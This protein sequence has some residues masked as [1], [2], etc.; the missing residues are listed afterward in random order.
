MT[1]KEIIKAFEQADKDWSKKKRWWNNYETFRNFT[2]MG[3]CGYFFHQQNV[4][5][6]D[7]DEFLC[8]LWEKHKTKFESVYDF[9]NRKERLKAIRKVLNVLKQQI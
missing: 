7:I 4:S 9:N 3:L 5:R 2:D 1:K 8:P 6:W